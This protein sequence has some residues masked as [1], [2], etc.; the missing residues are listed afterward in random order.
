[1]ERLLLLQLQTMVRFGFVGGKKAV[2]SFVQTK[3][4]I[5]IRE[6]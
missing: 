6:L 4:V 3:I 5:C 1:M 2:S